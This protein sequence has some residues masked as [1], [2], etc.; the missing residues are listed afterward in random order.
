M[1]KNFA[2][3]PIEPADYNRN[4][5]FGPGSPIHTK[6]PGLD[7]QAAFDRTGLVSETDMAKSFDAGQPA[8]VIDADTG[9]RQLIWAELDSSAS[10]GRRPQPVHPPRHELHRGPSLHR[11]PAQP[12]AGRRLGASSRRAPSGSTATASSPRS[13]TVEAR[14]AHMEDLFAPAR[15][16]GHRTRRPLPRLGLHRRQPAADRRAAAGDARRGASPSWATRTSPTSPSRARR[17]R[18]CPASARPTTTS[19]TPRSC[20]CAAPSR[21]PA[22]STSRCVRR[23][24]ASRSP[25]P[26]ATTRCGSRATRWSPTTTASCPR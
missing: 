12:Q 1:P 21:C 14:R 7:N 24:R 10:L 20:A 22:S 11:R 25:T 4:D 3:K 19:R 23:A 6:I 16:G 15:E 5:G 9:E 17:P 18:S 2:G 26:R 13:P 8:V